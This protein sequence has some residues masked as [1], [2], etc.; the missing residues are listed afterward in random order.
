MLLQ[1]AFGVMKSC[2]HRQPAWRLS[3]ILIGG[4]T[5]ETWSLLTTDDM[6]PY[7]K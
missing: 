4:I 7:S 3:V 6:F 5:L 1:P 2:P